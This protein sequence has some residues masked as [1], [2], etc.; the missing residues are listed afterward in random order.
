MKSPNGVLIKISEKSKVPLC[1]QAPLMTILDEYVD[2]YG[3]I[4]GKSC[5]VE[6]LKLVE[7]FLNKIQLHVHQ[8]M[9]RAIKHLDH[10]KRVR[11]SQAIIFHWRTFDKVLCYHS[12]TF[13]K[14]T[15]ESTL[16]SEI[17]RRPG[18]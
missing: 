17:L 9:K 14:R 5:T 18:C 16:R 13:N 15:L 7:S 6:S 1:F 12:Q 10:A 11:R 3:R 2:K 4:N 8:T